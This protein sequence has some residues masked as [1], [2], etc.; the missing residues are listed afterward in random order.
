MCLVSIS[1]PFSLFISL[2]LATVPV[3]VQFLQVCSKLEGGIIICI[4]LIAAGL[5]QTLMV[6]NLRHTCSVFAADI[7]SIAI[8]VCCKCANRN[9]P[10]TTDLIAKLLE[11]IQEVHKSMQT[12]IEKQTQVNY[13]INK[14]T[15]PL[16]KTTVRLSTKR[17]QM[18]LRIGTRQG[19][20]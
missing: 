4:T 1:S 13:N 20:L 15:W 10:T 9:S 11:G 5:Q 16:K 6:N 19:E 17:S 14:P 12:M 3:C 7:V 2:L 8:H 18:Q